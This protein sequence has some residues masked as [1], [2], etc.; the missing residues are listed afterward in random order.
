MPPDGIH[1]SKKIKKV[2]GRR[3]INILEMERYRTRWWQVRRTGVRLLLIR[4]GCTFAG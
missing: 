3:M 2:R 4:A 1:I